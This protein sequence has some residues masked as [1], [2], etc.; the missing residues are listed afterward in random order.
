VVDLQYA[1][2]RSGEEIILTSNFWGQQQWNISRALTPK[3]KTKKSLNCS[4]IIAYS[5]IQQHL[6]IRV[7]FFQFCEVSGVVVIY[8]TIEPNNLATDQ[9]GE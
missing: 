3:C 4:D 1:R 2:G 6:Q 9:R 8:K 5:H 7:F